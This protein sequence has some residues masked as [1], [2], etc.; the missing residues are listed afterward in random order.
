MKDS[1]KYLYIVKKKRGYTLKIFT[2][3]KMIVTVYVIFYTIKAG[4]NH[5][6]VTT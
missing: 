3:S 4:E 5:E 1:V 2:K 6:K